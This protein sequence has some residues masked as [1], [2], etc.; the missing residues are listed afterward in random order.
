MFADFREARRAIRG[1][2][3]GCNDCFWSSSG[4]IRAVRG[5][6]VGP[7]EGPAFSEVGLQFVADYCLTDLAASAT[8]VSQYA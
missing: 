6:V 3:R 7:L 1:G 2:I 4:V 8:L 5:I